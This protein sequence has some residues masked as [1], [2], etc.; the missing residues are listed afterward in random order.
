[1][2]ELPGR[3]GQIAA[4][5]KQA[6]EALGAGLERQRAKGIAHLAQQHWQMPLKASPVTL[7]EPARALNFG[8]SLYGQI[9]QPRGC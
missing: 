2:N 7:N 5:L 4:L 3:T 8:T 6:P 1:M 9:I